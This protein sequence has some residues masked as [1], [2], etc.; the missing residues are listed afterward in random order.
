MRRAKSLRIGVHIANAVV[1]GPVYRTRL[2]RRR[3]PPPVDC[4]FS[5]DGRAMIPCDPENHGLFADAGEDPTPPGSVRAGPGDGDRRPGRRGDD[6]VRAPPPP[7]AA[8]ARRAR[9]SRRSRAARAP[10]PSSLSTSLSEHALEAYDR[11]PKLDV[12][13]DDRRRRCGDRP[14]WDATTVAIPGRVRAVL[15][16]R[17][18]GWS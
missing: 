10:P 13:N 5:G 2:T 12:P 8:A 1:W 7:P 16:E 15:Y 17:P 9:R 3:R 11:C 18:S 4:L 6:G 14:R